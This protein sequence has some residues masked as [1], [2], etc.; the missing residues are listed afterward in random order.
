MQSHIPESHLR[1]RKYM[2]NIRKNCMKQHGKIDLGRKGK[3]IGAYELF[4]LL[5]LFSD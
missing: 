4:T 3:K 2:L 1:T 5:F